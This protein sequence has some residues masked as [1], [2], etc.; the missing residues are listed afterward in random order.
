VTDQADDHEANWQ[1]RG[2]LSSYTVRHVLTA[3]CLP[4]T[5]VHSARCSSAVICRHQQS[6]RTD[7]AA[8]LQQQQQQHCSSRWSAPCT[9][10]DN[11]LSRRRDTARHRMLFRNVT[12]IK[13][14]LSF[15]E[16][17]LFLLFLLNFLQLS[18]FD[19]EW[20]W[21]ETLDLKTYTTLYF[22]NSL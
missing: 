13:Q 17:I 21:T 19:L 15:Y 11:K 3:L 8:S 10:H 18:L 20:P 9:G 1:T 2:F 22:V 16:Y 6:Q 12:C 14:T 7:R 5:S 4:L